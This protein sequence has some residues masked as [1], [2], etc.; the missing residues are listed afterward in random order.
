MT[1]VFVGMEAG[2]G[3]T[4]IDTER[5]LA[6]QLR[7]HEIGD[8]Y[9]RYIERVAPDARLEP[10]TIGL[11][12]DFDY[13]TVFAGDAFEDAF[14]GYLRS[15]AIGPIP[16]G[17]VFQQAYSADPRAAEPVPAD[18]IV[19]ATAAER[20]LAAA[21]GPL[22]GID[23]TRPTVFVVN[24]YGRPDFVFHTYGFLG[25]RP[26]T[27]FPI[28]FTHAGQMVAWGGSPADVPYGALGREARVWFYDVS[29]GPDWGSGNWLLGPADVNGDGVTDHRIPP[30]WEYGTDH[31]Y[32][33]FDDVTADLAKLLRFVAVDALFAASP[34]Y[35]PALSE[36]LLADDIE[37]DL[38]IFSGW[39]G[40]PPAPALAGLRS[41]FARLDPTRRFEI[42]AAAVPLDGRLAE[43]LDCQQSAFGPHPRSCF[44][45]AP[46]KVEVV[47]P[48]DPPGAFYDLDRYF[49]RHGH[50][51]LDER[52]YELPLAVF[53]APDERLALNQLAGYASSRPPNNQGWTFAW[54][55]P[56]LRANGY[57][58]AGIVGHEAGH[59]L[60]LSH[61]HDAYDPIV[62][63]DFTSTGPFFFAF[64]GAEA[65]SAMSYIPNTDEFGQFDRDH[66]ARWQLAA[67]L[68]NAN[69][70][71][72]EVDR[73]PRAA[74]AAAAAQRGRCQRR[75]GADGA[76]RV[77]APGRVVR[78]G[79][80]VP[81]HARRGGGSRRAGRAL[82]G[83]GRRGLQR[84]RR[85]RRGDRP[86]RR[87]AAAAAGHRARP[88]CA[89]LRAVT[90]AQPPP[91]A[92]APA[93]SRATS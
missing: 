63:D 93:S 49:A 65:H 68:D 56:G 31:W 32:R 44:G 33:P 10:A 35:D 72:G 91:C 12:Y 17:T 47:E 20:W 57:T 62:D 41:T 59:H 24:W 23:T 81:P 14:F 21:A 77:A 66:M 73:S 78:G 22:L 74:Q 69:R 53:D 46:P 83:G 79:G 26:G 7:S 85:D 54:L 8:R 61:L 36:P 86:P 19:D 11:S 88:V 13:R 40:P 60:G 25:Q 4:R 27:A 58:D 3:P 50:Q 5:L 15:I 67:R 1:V 37:L 80:G 16:G 43:V 76:E 45:D 89:A 34:I 9:T 42:D 71:L 38:N 52:R 29:A 51:Y 87:R 30:I 70:I 2:S 64:S 75:R 28:G 55:T 39:A 90:R 48:T 92:P 6:P 18:F 84:R 82:R